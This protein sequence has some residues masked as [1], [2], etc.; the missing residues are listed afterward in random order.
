MS[1]KDDKTLKILL[2]SLFIKQNTIKTFVKK[3]QVIHPSV[4]MLIVSQIKV[5][6]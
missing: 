4:C 2:K 1:Y 5:V 6:M 3:K